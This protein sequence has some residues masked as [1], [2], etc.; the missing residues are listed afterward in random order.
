MAKVEISGKLTGSTLIDVPAPDSTEPTPTTNPSDGDGG[1]GPGDTPP[2]PVA[3]AEVKWEVT[4]DGTCRMTVTNVQS[5]NDTTRGVPNGCGVGLCGAG[6][7]EMLPL[8]II[9]LSGLRLRRRLQSDRRS[10]G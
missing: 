3:Q 4:P 6:M 8:T 10:R 1:D 5:A 7:V 2:P 9:G